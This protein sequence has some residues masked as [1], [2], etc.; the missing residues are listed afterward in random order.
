MAVNA[1]SPISLLTFPQ[2]WDGAS[3]VV[4]FLCLPRVSPL[5]PLRDALT[6]FAG[7]NFVFRAM[8]IGSLDRLPLPADATSSGPLVLDEPPSEKSQLFDE[9]ASEF[10]IVA[11]TPPAL[12][13]PPPKFLKAMTDSYRSLIGNRTRSELLRDP[14]EFT[15]ALHNGASA[16]PDAPQPPPPD[17]TWGQLIAH[18]LRQPR[19]ATALGLMGQVTVTPADPSFFAQGGWIYLD[20]DPTSDFGGDPAIANRY[21]ARLPTL[22]SP[23]PVFPAL[24][25]PVTS[26]PTP[27]VFDDVAAEAE[28]YDDGLAKLVHCAQGGGQG[29]SIQIGWDDEQVAEWLERQ[30]QIG[31]AG[32]VDAPNGVAGY[33]VDVRLQGTQDWNS[34]SRMESLGDLQ[35]GP[36][37]LGGFQGE[38]IVEIAPAQLLPGGEFWL[39]SYFANWRGSSLVLTDADLTDLHSR[40]EVQKG[41]SAQLLDR[42][43]VF[44]PVGDKAVPLQYGQTYEFRVRLADLTRGGPDVSAPLP[45]PARSSIAG[46]LFQR[47]KPPGP[48]GIVELPR[49]E[50][51]QLT[52]AK[53]RLGHPEAL[54]TGSATF[55]DLLQ[56]LAALAADPTLVR[57]ISVPDPDVVTL[58]I[59]VEAKSLDGDLAR[60]LTLYTTTRTFDQDELTIDLAFEDHATMLTI[61]VEQPADGPLALPT[62]RDLRL[63]LVSIGRDKP[64]YFVDDDA[65]RGAPITVSF[66]AGAVSEANLL[67]DPELSPSLRSFF[68][69]PPPP[70]NTVSPP[71]AR[72]A[73]ELG[74]DHSD[75]TLSGKAGRRTVMGCSAELAHTLAPDSSAIT[76]SSS[77]DLLR[78]WINVVQFDVLRDWTW[79]GLDTAGITITRVVHF[80]DGTDLTELEGS[81]RLP[82][83]IG[84]KAL[85]G[86]TPLPRDP[87]RQ[88]TSL[89]FF[90]AFDPKPK[91]P[92]ILP[93]EITI[94]Y[95]LEPVFQGLAPVEV[96]SRSI[97][98]PIT[99]PPSRTPSVFSAGIALSPFQSADDYS[100][101][102]QRQRML[103]LDLNVRGDPAAGVPAAGDS[104]YVRVLAQAPDPLLL[105]GD[106]TLPDAEESPLPIDPEW[107]RA[108]TPGQPRDQSG[109]S[110]M[111]ELVPSPES[112]GVYIVPLPPDLQESSPELFG[113][114]VYEIRLGHNASQW[115]TA[116]GRFG[117]P[118]RVAG[119]QHPAPP[120]VCQAVRSGDGVLVQ[121]PFAAAVLNGSRFR[122]GDTNLWALLYTRVRQADGSAYRNV[123]INRVQLVET[124][125]PPIIDHPDLFAPRVIFGQGLFETD[126]ITS[127]L[128]RLGLPANQALTVLAAEVFVNVGA[129]Q[130][131]GVAPAAVDPLGERLGFARILRISPLV[132]VPD[133]C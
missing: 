30:V 58:E 53:P 2:S 97:L 71:G 47:R 22:T 40:P 46:L 81:V 15:C 99:T 84:G 60:Y 38:G 16:Q 130:Q 78:R 28:L 111:Q 32:G 35:L 23:R 31:A 27:F 20:L 122:S 104:F 129:R 37:S 125:P 75:L 48:V 112:P 36:F 9:L 34:L 19:L 128:G 67:G 132:S 98:L 109:L 89:I 5:V 73:D 6:S 43:K 96:T 120:L 101:T 118:L 107:M 133:S 29:D 92:G 62:A 10:K 116:Q 65:R 124:P 68:F 63:T 14:D 114:F 3:L 76:F 59:T 39:P 110:A 115:S 21:A 105:P 123:L 18:T 42:E 93:S 52:I 45:D 100:S 24:L 7:S 57:E 72:L 85:I 64:G 12:P 11:R 119:V 49:P 51:R 94:E 103:W 87:A 13:P 17:I 82:T 102:A 91:L 108:I 33:R 4:R 117:P 8:L 126:T 61:P 26:G 55:E 50:A 131:A 106:M 77:T 54:F 56:D 69:Q 88:A 113:F 41:G 90:D 44:R 25:F 80:P 70:D 79:S 83:V 1:N 66:R 95:R 121:A 74:L 86:G 127:S